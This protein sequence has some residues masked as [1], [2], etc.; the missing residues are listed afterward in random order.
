[1]NGCRFAVREA[2]GSLLE[3]EYFVCVCVQKG[4]ELP[5][6]VNLVLAVLNLG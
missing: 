5:L 1:M 4:T 3:R 6:P 2:D